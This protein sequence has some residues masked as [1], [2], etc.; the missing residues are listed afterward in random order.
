MESP[1]HYRSNPRSRGH[2]AS[3][4]PTSNTSLMQK[5]GVVSVMEIIRENKQELMV[6]G[7]SIPISLH[8][9]RTN[10]GS[11]AHTY[12]T[13]SPP[14]PRPSQKHLC[15]RLV[16]QELVTKSYRWSLCT[17]KL[18]TLLIGRKR[19]TKLNYV[20]LSSRGRKFWSCR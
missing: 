2:T 1:V 11:H 9:K 18:V 14:S 8:A 10:M 16:S 13:S 15:T 17:T 5:S 6:K 4:D 7:D 19:Y 12:F 20:K 3:F